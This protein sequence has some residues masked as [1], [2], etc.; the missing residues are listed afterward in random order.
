MPKFEGKTDKVSD[1]RVPWQKY[2]VMLDLEPDKKVFPLFLYY[3]T[4]WK[5]SKKAK[6]FG[7]E[8]INY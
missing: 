4:I 7:L 6:Y 5:S 1:L 2:F 8:N 3:Y